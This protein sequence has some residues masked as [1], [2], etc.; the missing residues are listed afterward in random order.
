MRGQTGWAA[1]AE[2]IGYAPGGGI[3]RVSRHEVAVE[4]IRRARDQTAVIAIRDADEDA[5]SA[6][7]GSC[8]RDASVLERFPSRLEQDS[9]LRIEAMG[10]ARRDLE[11]RRIEAV[12]LAQKTALPRPIPNRR[13]KGGP[14][15]RQFANGVAPLGEQ[16]PVAFGIVRAAGKAAADPDNGNRFAAFAFGGQ[17]GRPVERADRA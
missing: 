4:T 3:E 16:A 13:S 6:A 8:S 12:Y 1:Q 14:V 10:F 17:P 5:G 7:T 15:S 11:Q 9:L 2:I